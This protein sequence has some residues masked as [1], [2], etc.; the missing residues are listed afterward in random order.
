VNTPTR[1]LIVDDSATV[2]RLINKVVSG[3]VFNFDVNEAA[4]GEKALEGL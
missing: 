1:A 4:D 3:S 2:R